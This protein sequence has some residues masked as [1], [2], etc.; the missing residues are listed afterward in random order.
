[1]HRDTNNILKGKHFRMS[2]IKSSWPPQRC[3]YNK[4]IWNPLTSWDIV[5]C[6]LKN[7][8]DKSVFISFEKK[9]SWL[10]CELFVRN[11]LK[12]SYHTFLSTT[13]L[14]EYFSQDFF[15]FILNWLHPQE[16][17]DHYPDLM[18]L[19]ILISGGFSKWNRKYFY[20]S[21]CDS[22]T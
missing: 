13:K 15:F 5:K 21:L 14:M 3:D 9:I 10:S 11:N 8:Q 7:F 19:Y 4:N 12:L 22:F 16:I 6:N 20:V 18:C 1:M 17:T 2:K